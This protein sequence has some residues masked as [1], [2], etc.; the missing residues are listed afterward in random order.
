MIDLTKQVP[1]VYVDESRDFQLYLRLLN[2]IIGGTK[3]TIDNIV[4]I[5]DPK[6]CNNRVL[7]L[8]CT[9]FNFNP[10]IKFTDED[11]RI[12]LAGFGSLIKN[13]GTRKGIEQAISLVLKT[14]NISS[15]YDVIVVNKDVLIDPELNYYIQITIPIEINQLYLYELLEYVKPVGYTINVYLITKIETE[16]AITTIDDYELR[17]NEPQYVGRVTDPL[18]QLDRT[19]ITIV[20]SVQITAEQAEQWNIDHSI[21]H[22]E[23]GILIPPE[24][25]RWLIEEGHAQYREGYTTYRIELIRHDSATNLWY[26]DNKYISIP[27]VDG[28]PYLDSI[29]RTEV[30]EPQDEN[31][32]PVED[33]V[34]NQDSGIGE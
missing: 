30:V 20:S 3:F 23:E 22:T 31:Y 10:K 2:V 14:Q 13:K 18:E 11:L 8:L 21:R 17:I 4:D 26:K 29:I 16:S 19:I 25:N 27:I 34:V 5:Y 32:E 1:N 15:N 24:V 28:N 12:I 9:T 7:N 33:I 6:V